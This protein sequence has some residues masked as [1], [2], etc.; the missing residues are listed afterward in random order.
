MNTPE[1]EEREQRLERVV[2]E[3]SNE[4]LFA[5]TLWEIASNTSNASDVV[6]AELLK[7]SGVSEGLA[8]W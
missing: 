4:Q 1:Y 6:C 7:R 2:S 3:M 8:K 5:L